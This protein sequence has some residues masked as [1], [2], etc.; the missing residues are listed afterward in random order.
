[1]KQKALKLLKGEKGFSLIELLIVIAILTILAIVIIPRFSTSTEDSKKA[2]DQSNVK[3]LQSAVERY[4][5]DEGEYPTADG[6]LPASGST[7]AIDYDKLIDG[8]YIDEA[9]TD[10]WTD[11]EA[12]Y[13]LDSNGVV[14]PLKKP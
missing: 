10:P 14:E 11:N 7:T 9:P 4:H 5:F 8:R 12:V 6:K 3:L 2:A 13:K 1:M